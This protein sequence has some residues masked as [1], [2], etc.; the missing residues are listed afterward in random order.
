[1]ADV[2]GD[3][4]LDIVTANEGSSSV[5]VLLG[6]GNG[7]FARQAT[8]STANGP[9]SVALGDVNGDGKLDIVTPQSRLQ[10]QR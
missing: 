2:N 1:L 5:S 8:F 10:L 3:G 7:S 6:T 4:T 9:Y